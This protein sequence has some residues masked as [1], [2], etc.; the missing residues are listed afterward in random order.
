MTDITTP[1]ITALATENA[2]LR[3]A[4]ESVRADYAKH[5]SE[6]LLVAKGANE[7]QAALAAALR[8]RD[9]FK[10]QAAELEPRAKLVAELESKVNAY[11]N[12]ERESAIVETIRAK[13]DLPLIAIRGVLGQLHDAGKVN[14]YSED[15]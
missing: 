2:S 5:Q 15:R 1:D 3:G 12:T 10:T 9:T 7:S 14:K 13:Y 8:E 6:T 11:V 4:L